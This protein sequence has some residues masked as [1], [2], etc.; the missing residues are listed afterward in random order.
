MKLCSSFLTKER[1]LFP[2]HQARK[3]T[4]NSL[5]L[6]RLKCDGRLVGRLSYWIRWIKLYRLRDLWLGTYV[7]LSFSD[8]SPPFLISLF[9]SLRHSSR[10]RLPLC[11]LPLLLPQP[12]RLTPLLML[13]PRLLFPLKCNSE[14]TWPFF[15]EHS[16]HVFFSSTC[17]SKRRPVR[18]VQKMH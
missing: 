8:S 6:D 9:Q 13:S 1:Q 16:S 17:T 18:P 12:L 14:H 3:M 2:L 11:Q 15:S 7:K 10:E 5:S 4:G